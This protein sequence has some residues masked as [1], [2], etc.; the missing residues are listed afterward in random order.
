MKRGVTGPRARRDG[1][2]G[3]PLPARLRPR[4]PSRPA[5][6]GAGAGGRAEGP[7][8]SQ[9]PG[10]AREGPAAAPGAPVPALRRRVAPGAVGASR[11]SFAWS[12]GGCK[13]EVSVKMIT[14]KSLPSLSCRST[15]RLQRCVRSSR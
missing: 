14:N 6:R 3:P 8:L 5:L 11:K 1:R 12:K 2:A 7:A 13:E 10:R 9:R 4:P 15:P